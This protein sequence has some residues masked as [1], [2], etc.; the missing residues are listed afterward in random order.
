V[1]IPSPSAEQLFWPNIHIYDLTNV[2]LQVIQDALGEVEGK[3]GRSTWNEQGYY[4][5]ES[6]KHYWQEVARWIGEECAK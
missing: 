2:Y 1:K 6:G 5:A 3:K 4:F